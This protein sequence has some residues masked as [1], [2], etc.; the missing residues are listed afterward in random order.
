MNQPHPHRHDSWMHKSIFVSIGI[1][2]IDGL[3]MK[4]RWINEWVACL[5][6]RSLKSE[7]KS[8]CVS[9]SAE[10]SVP[11]LVQ[12]SFIYTVLHCRNYN[13]WADLV[14]L[15]ESRTPSSQHI[16]TE[17]TSKQ[18]FRAPLLWFGLYVQC[19]CL[20]KLNE[21]FV[22]ITWLTGKRISKHKTSARKS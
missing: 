12:I 4:I 3:S 19:F 22:F 17:H 13:F 9:S 18:A 10:I 14:T 6:W 15:T 8:W 5:Q 11:V 20:G 7:L 16:Q 2:R 1:S 21:V